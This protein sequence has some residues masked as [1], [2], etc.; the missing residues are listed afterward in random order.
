MRADV[1]LIVEI[2]MATTDQT[3]GAGMTTEEVITAITD[4]MTEKE[5][6]A[7]HLDLTH[8]PKMRT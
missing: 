8:L 7:R 2:E 6:R 5:T 1:T 4:E 3:H